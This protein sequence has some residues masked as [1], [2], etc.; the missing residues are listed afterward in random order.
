MCGGSFS[1]KS[2]RKIFLCVEGHLAINQDVRS[3]YVWRAISNK[4]ERTI[5]VY[6]EGHLAI[7]QDVR[8]LYVW[9]AI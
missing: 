7:N 3:L 9:R 4:S 1:N 5:F 2:R 6:M 8:S